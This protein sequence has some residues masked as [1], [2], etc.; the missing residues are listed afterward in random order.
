MRNNLWAQLFSVIA[1]FLTLACNNEPEISD[2]NN[3]IADHNTNKNQEW[4]WNDEPIDGLQEWIADRQNDDNWE[5]PQIY[6]SSLR[7]L[8]LV[9][10]YWQASFVLCGNEETFFLVKLIESD[11]TIQNLIAISSLEGARNGSR[12]FYF[13][14]FNLDGDIYSKELLRKADY[15][16]QGSDNFTQMDGDILFYLNKSQK[17]FRS[18]EIASR[19]MNIKVNRQELSSNDNSLWGRDFPSPSKNKEVKILGNGTTLICTN[20]LGEFDTLITQEYTG[21]WSIGTVAWSTDENK[22]YFD[23]SGGVA[24]I[25]EIDLVARTI[26]KI[27]AEHEASNPIYL[28]NNGIASVIYCEN[29]CIKL[30]QDVGRKMYYELIDI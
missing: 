21:N 7:N 4:D 28:L 17:D 12:E 5:Q 24:C 26:D 15:H 3:P 18:Y 1:S 2:N 13:Y 22:F 30:T 10:N 16:I 27:V 19:T 23:N 20:D 14:H 29:N 11:D 8:Q 9:Q 25:W 6:S